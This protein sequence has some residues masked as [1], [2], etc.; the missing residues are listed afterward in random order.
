M[1]SFGQGSTILD[2]L[3]EGLELFVAEGDGD[4]FTRELARPLIPRTR[5][6]KLG[7]IHH[8]TFADVAE[9]G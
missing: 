4:C 5:S 9:G 1:E 7:A 6:L 3:A 8:G 2:R